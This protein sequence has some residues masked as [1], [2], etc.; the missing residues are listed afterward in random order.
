MYLVG[1]SYF[2]I[3]IDWACNWDYIKRQKC[4]F[5]FPV[6]NSFYLFQMTL[7]DGKK[8]AEGNCYQDSDSCSESVSSGSLCRAVS[9]PVF[10]TSYQGAGP[11][12]PPNMSQTRPS[13]AAIGSSGDLLAKYQ[14][15]VIFYH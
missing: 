10:G 9:V 15:K 7:M 5:H 12:Q 13:S 3:I 6:T 2:W 11:Q 14:A 8:A 4:Y 1:Q